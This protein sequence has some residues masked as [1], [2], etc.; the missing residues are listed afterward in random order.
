M[1][2]LEP[3]IKITFLGIL[4]LLFN[5]EER[6][7]DVGFLHDPPEG[8][9]LTIDIKRSD[10]AGTSSVAPRITAANIKSRLRLDVENVS[11]SGAHLFTQPGFDRGQAR[12]DEN[13]FQWAIDFNTDLYKGAPAV[14][15]DDFKA[16]MSINSGKFFTDRLSEDELRLQQGDGEPTVVG[17]VATIIG[18]NIFL[19]RH[20]SKAVFVNGEE[21]VFEFTPEPGVTYQI[22]IS[23]SP[24]LDTT[25]EPTSADSNA[26]HA[27]VRPPEGREQ[28]QFLLPEGG[29]L[30]LPVSAHAV[31]FTAVVRR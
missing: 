4:V 21:K 16:V 31:C 7:C 12:G 18:A 17:R 20:N 28:I 1:P 26:Y 10:S 3:T 29:P 2:L 30:P 5:E 24:P 8:H 14:N 27:V 19:D 15:L 9:D 22:D 25:E 11:L 23:Q 6:R 13:D